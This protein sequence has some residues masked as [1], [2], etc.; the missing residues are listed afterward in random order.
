MKKDKTYFIDL[1][2]K[3]CYGAYNNFLLLHPDDLE[4]LAEKLASQL[5]P[6]VMQKIAVVRV[7]HILEGI[8][9]DNYDIKAWN[10][11]NEKLKKQMEQLYSKT[12]IKNGD[13]ITVYDNDGDM[14]FYTVDHRAIDIHKGK[15]DILY[16]MDDLR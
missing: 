2:T 6:L 16:W 10:E 1:I 15:L 3:H 9:D 4:K 14:C 11:T 7:A 13:L 5:E 12:D 8:D